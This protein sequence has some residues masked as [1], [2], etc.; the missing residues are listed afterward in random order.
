MGL[1]AGSF[2]MFAGGALGL[3]GWIW[4]T[5]VAFQHR[6]Q[7]WGWLLV[8]SIFLPIG[9]FVGLAFAILRWRIARAPAMLIL[10]SGLV[11]IFGAFLMIWSAQDAQ[12]TLTTSTSS[13]SQEGAPVSESSAPPPPTDTMVHPEATPGAPAKAARAPSS[14]ASVTPPKNPGPGNESSTPS[15]PGRRSADS[16]RDPAR[17]PVQLEVLQLGDPAPNQLR[18]LRVLARNED[19]RPVRELKIELEYLDRRGVRLGRWTTVHSDS[20]AVVGGATSSPVNLQAFFVPQ[21]TKS[22]RLGVEGVVFADGTRWP[23]LE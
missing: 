6:E 5:R 23:S 1:S 7:V 13:A 11:A 12:I 8:A 4:L 22:V 18:L 10:G 15:T 14:P 2:L 21:F 16:D 9:P 19:S 20:P 3:A 17:P